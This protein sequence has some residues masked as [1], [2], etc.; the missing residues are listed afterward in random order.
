MKDP[1]FFDQRLD[2][3]R[4]ALLAVI[5]TLLATVAPAGA[6][7]GTATASSD[8]NGRPGWV[9]ENGAIRVGL[10]RGGGHI[11]EL[12]M[13]SANP[14]LSINPMFVP[15]PRSASERSGPGYMGHLVCFPHYG[16]AS[17]EE[18]AQ[19]LSGHGEAGSVEWRETRPARASS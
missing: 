15:A 10:L 4:P 17:A 8:I 9:L 2:D 14:R 11:A 16:P 6:Q 19:G 5:L 1:G 13:I 7:S 3:G 18:R 12:R